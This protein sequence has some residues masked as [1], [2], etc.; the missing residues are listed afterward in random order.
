MLRQTNYHDCGL[1][2]LTYIEAIFSN[3][4]T[5]LEIS[6]LKNKN[7]LSLFPRRIIHTMR[8]ELKNLLYTLMKN[9]P[10]DEK[11]D[12]INEFLK[13]RKH[14]I[15]NNK[16]ANEYDTI[17]QNYFEKYCQLIPNFS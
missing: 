17:N 16:N 1:Y 10:D 7:Y 14:I 15:N 3:P 12:K 9:I 4:Q 5:L 11:M 6:Q 8:I 13:K 2:I